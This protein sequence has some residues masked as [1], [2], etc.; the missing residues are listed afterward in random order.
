[1]VWFTKQKKK[2]EKVLPSFEERLLNVEMDI[3]KLKNENIALNLDL[4]SMR[5]KVLRKIQQKKTQEE[6]E[7]DTDSFGFPLTK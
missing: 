2:E 6:E 4:E 5:N 1:M 7:N 3:R